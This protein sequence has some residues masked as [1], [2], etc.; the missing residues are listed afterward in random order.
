ML[1]EITV[2]PI[3]IRQVLFNLLSNALRHTPAGGEI[4]V[5]GTERCG[6]VR[7][8]VQDTGEGLEPDQLASVFD[9]FYRAD[10]RA[11]GKRAA[12]GWGWRSSK[13]S[14]KPTAVAWKR[15]ARARGAG[16]HS[17]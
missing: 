16:A 4:V 11:A 6:E 14:S 10:N 3:R 13:R 9:R 2:D 5:T 7:L 15:T 1:P 17:W 8:T 12:P